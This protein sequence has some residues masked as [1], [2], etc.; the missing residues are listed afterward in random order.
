M[1][2]GR[3]RGNSTQRAIGKGVSHAT[4][5]SGC[6][7]SKFSILWLPFYF[8]I[9]WKILE[10]FVLGGIL[11]RVVMLIGIPIAI[12]ATYLINQKK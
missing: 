2:R 7:F 11:V 3:P 1:G 12:I 8:I 5:S 4:K 9:F 6:L 10:V